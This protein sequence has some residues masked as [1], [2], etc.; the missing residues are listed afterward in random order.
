MPMLRESSSDDYQTAKNN[1]GSFSQ[2]S[3]RLETNGIWPIWPMCL[4]ATPSMYVLRIAHKVA[5]II[6]AVCEADDSCTH[7]IM[8]LYWKTAT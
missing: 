4:V 8:M 1:E 3:H 2:P 6:A 5:V 7:K